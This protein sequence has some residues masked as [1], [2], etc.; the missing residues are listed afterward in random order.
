[1]TL[2]DGVPLAGVSGI[3]VVD[4]LPAVGR[5]RLQDL[6]SIH[7]LYFAD[8]GHVLAE[9]EQAWAEGGFDPD[10]VV[11]QWLLLHAGEPAG[12]FIFHT[13]LRRGIVARHFLALGAQAREGLADDWAG[14]LVTAAQ[15]HAEMDARERGV[16][17][18]A[19]MSEIDPDQ[20]RLIAHWRELGHVSV[21]SIDYREP[22]HGKHWADFGDPRF[23]P[24][25]A[26]IR[27]TDAGLRRPPGEVVSAAVAAFLLDHYR[28]PA[29]E[30]TVAAILER[31][32]AVQPADL[33]GS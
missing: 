4:V 23:F 17:I 24:M 18:L 12:E 2:R 22:Y 8:H 16:E 7:M 26:N 5:Q 6:Q 19:L 33:I 13:N 1:M 27:F 28:L 32:R 14:H 9:M 20:P 21:P 15:R 30:P 10:I 25:I 29:D 11:H 3:D 31:A